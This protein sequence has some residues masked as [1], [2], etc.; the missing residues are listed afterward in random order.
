MNAFKKN[1]QLLS[2]LTLLFLSAPSLAFADWGINQILWDIVNKVFGFF[3]GIAGSLLNYAIQDFVVGFSNQFTTQGAGAV[4]DSLWV[5]V[6]DIFN[7]TFIFGLVYIGFKMILNSDDSG[8]RRWLV[9]L[10]LAAL[11]VNFSLFF[12]KLIVDFSNLLA[13]Q[14]VNAGFNGGNISDVF[15]DNMGLTNILKANPSASIGLIFGAMMIYI[16]GTF[17]F[18]AGAMLLIIRYAALCLYMVMSPLMFLG[19]VFPGLQSVTSKYWSGFLGRAFFAPIYIL[20]LY[21]SAS[22]VIQ[23]FGPSPTPDFNKVFSEG[24]GIQAALMPFILVCIFLIASVV[25]ANKLGADGASQAINIGNKMRGWGQRK[26]VRGTTYAPRKAGGWAARGASNYTGNLA[27]RK[28]NQWQQSNNKY[29]R[30]LAGTTLVDDAVRGGA[31]TLKNSKYGMSDTVDELKKKKDVIVNRV[32][33]NDEISAGIAAQKENAYD[34]NKE[35]FDPTTNTVVSRTSLTGANLTNAE[36]SEEDREK[37]IATMQNHLSSMSQKELEDMYSADSQMFDDVIGNLKNDQFDRLQNS[38]N[39]NSTQK[40]DLLTKR[41]AAITSVI[42]EN[43]AIL[44]EDITNLSI[45]QI[46]T[47]GDDFIRQNSHLFTQGQMDAIQKSVM[48][49]EGQKGSY[50]GSRKEKQKKMAKDQNQVA[51]LFNHNKKGTPNVFD[52][53]KK[54]AEIANLPFEVFIST[55][56]S[57]NLQPNYDA[58]EYIDGS[59]LE[60]IFTKKTMTVEQ[61]NQLRDAIIGAPSGRFVSALNYLGTPLGTRNWM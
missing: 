34:H 3:M 42:S 25:V 61:R 27:N 31:A 12:T 37:K 23:F 6:R 17:V 4:V 54:A 13:T 18:A 41:Q 5:S 22:I 39:L 20:L 16:V 40:N 28:L 7:I 2:L 50:F 35:I 38:E 10:I 49:T 19:W 59:V 14:I 48:F 55:D 29:V 51:Q 58:I 57:G 32:K 43:G 33:R 9:S 60:E 21:F 15:M 47:M 52:K 44:T 53:N 24:G 30:G 45:K 46:E 1:T 11:L 36:K 56:Q 8:T 26:L